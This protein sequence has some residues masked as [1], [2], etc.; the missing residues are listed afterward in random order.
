MQVSSKS[1]YALRALVEL[2]LRTQ[3]RSRPVRVIDLANERGL[4]EQFLEQLFATLRRSG[5]LNSHRGAGGGFTFAHRPE[6]VTVLDVVESLDGPLS[7]AAC[8]G[9]DCDREELCG[10]SVVWHE[11]T[12]AFAA[13]LARTTVADLAERERQQGS[14]QAMYQI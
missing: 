7:V 3:G 6:S 10:A 13:V 1:R 11:A 14:G 4:P 2:E 5:I 9:G 8:I 12:A